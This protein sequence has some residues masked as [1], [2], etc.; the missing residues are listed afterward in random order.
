MCTPESSGT[1]TPRPITISTL[2]KSNVQDTLHLLPFNVKYDGTANVGGYFRPSK[3]TPLSKTNNDTDATTYNQ[4]LLVD[5]STTP[6]EE[7]FEATFRGRLLKGQKVQNPDG[8]VGLLLKEDD[9]D[10]EDNDEK[11]DCVGWSVVGEF[12][13]LTY[14]NRE[15]MP[16]KQDYYCK[17]IEWIKLANAIHKPILRQAM[18]QSTIFKIPSTSPTKKRKLDDTPEPVKRQKVEKIEERTMQQED[19]QTNVHGQ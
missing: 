2:S 1:I 13:E 16:S 7:L 11:Q 5:G 4:Q 9:K 3:I 19:Q 15:R 10:Y 18:E 6:P 8:Y 14:W 12:N 17:W